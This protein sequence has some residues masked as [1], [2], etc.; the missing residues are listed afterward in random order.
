MAYTLFLK[1]KKVQHD[2]NAQNYWRAKG[3]NFLA[4]NKQLFHGGG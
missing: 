3:W 2:E 1:I 4:F